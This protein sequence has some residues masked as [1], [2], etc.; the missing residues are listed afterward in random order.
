MDNF[1]FIYSDK[2]DTIFSD[3]NDKISYSN[4]Y[5][6]L[7]RYLFITNM[8]LWDFEIKVRDKYY[9]IDERMHYKECIDKTNLLRNNIIENI[10]NFIVK[11]FNLN[12]DAPLHTESLGNV[13]DRLSILKL[14][15]QNIKLNNNYLDKQKQIDIEI[16]FNSL[17]KALDCFINELIEG[18][19]NFVVNKQ[20]KD[21]RK[22]EDNY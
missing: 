8:K 21:Y 22:Y 11:R 16:Q 6:Y 19:K 1:Q 20:L 13:Y 17:K 3:V 14:R 10:D 2:A 9:Q 15:L 18:K 7:L 5:E 12:K 4:K